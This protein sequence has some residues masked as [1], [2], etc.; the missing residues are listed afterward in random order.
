LTKELY[1]NIIY[2][3]RNFLFNINSTY[4]WYFDENAP[5]DKDDFI[6]V[7][8]SMNRI[9][10]VVLPKWNDYISIN[11]YSKTQVDT[12]AAEI[13]EG[14]QNMVITVLDFYGGTQ[15]I[16]GYLEIEHIEDKFLTVLDT[17]HAVRNLTIY[18]KFYE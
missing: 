8:E 9:Q 12:I 2:S 13:I 15:N 4:E 1:L 18:Y 14:L 17:G 11:I 5:I 10:D 7:R 3:I 6:T 16:I